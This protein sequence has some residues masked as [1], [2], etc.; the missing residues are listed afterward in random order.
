MFD[1]LFVETTFLNWSFLFS[2]MAH[3]VDKGGTGS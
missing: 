2:G 1:S 3:F